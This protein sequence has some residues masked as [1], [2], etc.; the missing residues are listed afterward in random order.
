MARTGHLF[1]LDL[2]F[3]F[4][5]PQTGDRI[6]GRD[7]HV[8]KDLED[9]P[10]PPPGAPVLARADREGMPC[11]LET[12]TEGNVAFYRKRGFQVVSAGLVPGQSLRIWTMLRA[13]A[14]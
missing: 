11:Y 5:S 14:P 13:P 10:L 8:R 2:R 4:R 7:S 12:E 9:E 3:R 1:L 6:E